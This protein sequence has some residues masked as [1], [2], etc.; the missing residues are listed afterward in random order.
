MIDLPV[1]FPGSKHKRKPDWLRVKLPIGP[2]YAKVRKLVDNYKLHT[3]CESGNCPNMGECWGAGTATFMILGNICTRS[4]TFC[5][6]ATGRPTEYDLDEPKRVA[7]AIKLMGVKHA[8]I[9][10]VNRD[11]L[12][13]RGAE[14]WYQT[15]VETKKESPET[16]IETLIPDVKG[17]WDALYRMI[18]GGQEVVSHNMETVGRMYRIVRPQAKYDRSLEQIKRIREA[19]KRTKSGIMLGVGETKEE[20]FKALDDLVENQLMILTLG[21]YL[22]P[23]KMHLEVVE[24]IHPDTFEMYKEEG[25]KRGLKYVESGPLVRSSYHAERHVNVPFD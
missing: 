25:L 22:Q 19:G 5:A 9:T 17:N 24:Y 14:V 2:E 3:I 16:T 11:E 8:V 1:I 21:Q 15:V 10:S 13:D 18:D 12:K 4:C 20:V 7:K 6:V 23:T